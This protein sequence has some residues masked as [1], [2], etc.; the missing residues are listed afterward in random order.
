MFY[1]FCQRLNIFFQVQYCSIYTKFVCRYTFAPLFLAL[2]FIVFFLIFIIVYGKNTT[3]H[4]L[5]VTC[6]ER[7]LTAVCF[8]QLHCFTMCKN[9]EHQNSHKKTMNYSLFMYETQKL[10]RF[11]SSCEEFGGRLTV[12]MFNTDNN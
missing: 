6:L 2:A 8:S 9:I 5:A 12:F 10:F 3:A 1:L 4:I 11:L 7:Y